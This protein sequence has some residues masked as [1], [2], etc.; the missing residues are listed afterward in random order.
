MYVC[1]RG[2]GG[3]TNGGGVKCYSSEQMRMRTSSLS[4]LTTLATYYGYR[5]LS[6]RTPGPGTH[7]NYLP[8]NL[9]CMLPPLLPQIKVN[10]V[11]FLHNIVLEPSEITWTAEDWTRKFTAAC[12][13]TTPTLL[14]ALSYT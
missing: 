11:S 1:W 10:A 2:T 12:S 5:E 8:R 9:T 13:P 6:T 4:P 7:L 3:R 14:P